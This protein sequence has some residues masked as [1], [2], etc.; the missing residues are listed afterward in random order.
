MTVFILVFP[1]LLVGTECHRL[2]DEEYNILHEAVCFS[3]KLREGRF[4]IYPFPTTLQSPLFP[5]A[6]WWQSANLELKLAFILGVLSVLLKGT[7]K[8]RCRNTLNLNVLILLGK[9]SKQ[10]CSS[11]SQL[12]LYK[13]FVAVGLSRIQHNLPNQILITVLYESKSDVW[14]FFSF[15]LFD[16]IKP[17]MTHCHILLRTRQFCY[18]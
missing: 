1:F 9:C 2:T 14:V 5:C 6:A 4:Q 18:F 12:L 8:Q 15:P 17:S 3:G 10:K 7:C 11:F 16:G 13:N